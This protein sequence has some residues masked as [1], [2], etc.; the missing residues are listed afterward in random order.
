MLDFG[1]VCD[2]KQHMVNSNVNAR[3]PIF[4]VLALKED[5][6]EVIHTCNEF[7]EN[8]LLSNDKYDFIIEENEGHMA[9]DGWNEH[10]QK[11]LKA[12]DLHK[13]EIVSKKEGAKK[14]SKICIKWRD[15]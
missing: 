8:K 2:N 15:N 7:C 3:I 9:I 1:N 13:V 5:Y 4:D 10:C 12:S 14:S 6:D 11:M